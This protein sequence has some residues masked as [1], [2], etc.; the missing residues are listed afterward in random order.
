MHI[1]HLVFHMSNITPIPQ[2]DGKITFAP[3]LLIFFFRDRALLFIRALTC[4]QDTN[5][6]LEFFSNLQRLEIKIFIMYS[7]Y[8]LERYLSDNYR[9]VHTD[10][11][12]YSIGK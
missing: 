1:P 5:S 7:G 10:K 4:V 12:I 8:V 6:G 2:L 11:E 3:V 9:L